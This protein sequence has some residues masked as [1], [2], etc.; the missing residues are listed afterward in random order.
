MSIYFF[1]KPF[2]ATTVFIVYVPGINWSFRKHITML[3]NKVYMS[4]IYFHT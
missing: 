4:T 2:D 1:N 3:I